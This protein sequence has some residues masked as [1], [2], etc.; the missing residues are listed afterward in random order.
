MEFSCLLF[1]NHTQR[2]EVVFVLLLSFL[3]E[4]FKRSHDAMHI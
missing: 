4:V 1:L 2:E 3:G